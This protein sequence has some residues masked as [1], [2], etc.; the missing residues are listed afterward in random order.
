M[1]I[2]FTG[3]TNYNEIRWAAMAY[4][5]R[6]GDVRYARMLTSGL[7][8]SLPQGDAGA[9][10][11]LMQ[12]LNHLSCRIPYH[13]SQALSTAIGQVA[14]Q[15]SALREAELTDA[16]WDL[17][18]NRATI[19]SA[20]QRLAE[21]HGTTVAAKTLAVLNPKL[22]VMWDNAIWYACYSDPT[23]KGGTTAATYANFLG[24]M[25]EAAKTII[26]DATNREHGID[27]P[28][29]HLS[30]ALHLPTTFPLAK[31]IDEYNWLTISGQLQYPRQLVGEEGVD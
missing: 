15:I 23:L 31:F 20:F 26:R 1:T 9:V 22:F 24:R 8:K 16:T 7:P 18:S 30:E 25:R 28:A 29:Q 4:R 3:P 2:T 17:P 6:Y 12:W 27:S 19:E 10:D 13:K 5:G 14:P 21:V 11:H